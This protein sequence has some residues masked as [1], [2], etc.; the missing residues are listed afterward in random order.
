MDIHRET[1]ISLVDV[2][3]RFNKDPRTVRNWTKRKDNPLY[4]EPAGGTWMTTLEEVARWL[5]AA[6]KRRL[7]TVPIATCDRQHEAAE[8]RLK[9]VH[10]I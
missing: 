10:R 4:A 5:K 2:A 1:P 9:E 6:R 8:K 3:R 7:A